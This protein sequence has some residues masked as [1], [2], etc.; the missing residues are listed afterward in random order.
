MAAPSKLNQKLQ[1]K[2][3]NMKRAKSN[4]LVESKNK[5]KRQQL[6]D[7][8][9]RK[10]LKKKAKKEHRAAS[11]KERL[12]QKLKKQASKERKGEIELD[13]DG[14]II[15]GKSNFILIYSGDEE[16]GVYT[17]YV[18]GCAKLF[19]D[20]SSLRKHMMTHGER[21]YICPVDG[22][23]KRFLDNSKLKRHQLVHTGEKPF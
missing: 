20:S 13:G 17:C 19:Q 14:A 7:R 9:L 5:L 21:Q 8:K 4:L 18:L 6:L 10:K 2:S 23:N 12:N 15:D 1:L 16:G 3:L 22:C 11:R